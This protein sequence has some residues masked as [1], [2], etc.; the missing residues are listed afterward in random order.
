[1]ADTPQIHLDFEENCPDCGRRRAG[2]PA[3]L[4]EIGDD[5]DWLLRDYDGFRLF[6]M[7]ELMARFPQRA[8]WTPADM[9]V[10]LVEVLSSALDQLSDM[11][12]RVAGEAFLETARQ[13]A[14]VRRLLAMMGYDAVT[15]GG[16]QD[17]PPHLP[18]G[19]TAAEKL[20]ID[21]QAHPHLMDQARQ[22]GPAALNRQKRMVTEKDYALGLEA[23]PLVLYASARSVW[24]G[25]WQTV[26]AAVICRHHL[27]LDQ[28][29]GDIP[30]DGLDNDGADRLREH[31][32]QIRT[33]VEEFN[34]TRG[35]GPWDLDLEQ[36]T[37]RALLQA[38]VNRYRMAGQETVLEDA[39]PV[40]IAMAVSLGI[41]PAYFQSEI[42][43]A[44]S[45]ILGSEAGGFFAPGR[46][47]FGEDL[48]AGDI[49]QAL[50]AIEG[51]ETVCLN[52]FKRVGK[53]WPDCAGSGTIVLSDLETAVCDNAPGRPQQGYYTLTINGGK[54][55]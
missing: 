11:M 28:T 55:G 43:H 44:A 16:Y 40:G 33:D 54:K 50:L 30:F 48:H 20:D 5:F 23:H 37:I 21:W 25:S 9:E 13:P 17:D 53:G 1:M 47:G 42:R 46:R 26:R 32:Q 41:G 38:Y 51:V 19:K 31:I 39:L 24:N 3:P 10:V 12:D 45:R 29:L 34:L 22:S 35:L 14:S 36:P 49:F 18:H 6:M 2:L 8:R 7:E 27:L 4:P 15:R 52:R